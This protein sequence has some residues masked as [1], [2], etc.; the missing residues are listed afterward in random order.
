MTS[1]IGMCWAFEVVATSKCGGGAIML[2]S[3]VLQS[4]VWLGF[5]QA[6]GPSGLIGLSAVVSTE[7]HGG[8][9]CQ[10]RA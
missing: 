5:Q 1:R 4:W 9:G 8:E 2:C 6:R 10:V 7:S 3:S